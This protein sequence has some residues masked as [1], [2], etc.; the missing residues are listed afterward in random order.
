MHIEQGVPV[1][2]R[3]LNLLHDLV[4]ASVRAV[5]TRYIGNGLPAGDGRLRRC[6]PCPPD[7]TARTFRSRPRPA[8][9]GTI[10]VGGMEVTIPA[11]ITY[12]SQPGVP[13]LTTPTAGA[14]GPAAW[15]PCT[16]T[17]S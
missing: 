13:P 4:T 1:L 12:T 9:P 6:R 5:I 15:T 14:A 8:G 3:D 17:C 11:A 16:S 10:L 7:R 2:D